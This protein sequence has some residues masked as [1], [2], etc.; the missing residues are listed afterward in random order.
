LNRGWDL[1]VCEID[2]LE[3]MVI[4]R[5]VGELEDGFGDIVAGGFD[6]NIIVLLEVDAGLLLGWVVSYAEKLSLQT[7]VWWSSNVLPVSPL[8]VTSSASR[9]WSRTTAS[10]RVAIC[11]SVESRVLPGGIPAWASCGCSTVTTRG[12]IGS[13]GPVS[14]TRASVTS[15]EAVSAW[16][17]TL[18]YH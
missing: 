4:E 16:R 6:G 1:V 11:I 9:R 18:A 7:W 3:E 2:V 13:A 15:C 17:S 5:R 10:C 8:S 12:E 14:A